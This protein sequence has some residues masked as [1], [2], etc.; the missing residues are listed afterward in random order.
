MDETPHVASPLPDAEYLDTHTVAERQARGNARRSEVSLESLATWS[1]PA[2]RVDPVAVL[3][4]QAGHRVPELVPIRYGRMARVGLRLLP[5]RR[6]H[7]GGRPL[8]HARP[9]GCAPSSAATPT[10]STSA[11][12]RRPER[13]LVFGLNDF[14]ET[15]PGPVRVGRQA[16]RRQRRDRRPRPR[17]RRRPAAHG[18]GGHRPGLPRGHA[19]VR[20]AAQPRRLVRPPPGRRAAHGSPTTGRPSRP[21]KEVKKRIDAGA[22][23]AITCAPSAASVED[24]RR[25]APVLQPPAAARARSRSC[26]TSSSASATS[27][28]SSTFLR[29]YRE[30]L[31]PDRRVLVESYRFV[32][33]GPQGRRRRQRRHPRLGRA[34]RRPRRRRPADPPAQGGPAV[35]ARAL[36]RRDRLRVPGPP[37]R[38]GPAPHAGRQRP[39]LGWYRPRRLRRRSPRL[40]RAPAL[41]RQGLDRRLP[42]R[43]R[44]ASSPTARAAAGPSPAATPAPATASP[45]PPTSATT[46]PSSR[47]SPTFA[48]AYADT[49]EAD[50]A[51]LREAETSG[52]VEVVH[53]V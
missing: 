29:Q 36:R 11:S 15:L 30:S 22:Q 27:R 24:G 41:G 39:L 8:R 50:H 49:N 21:A 35:G 19:R 47:R 40:L 14:D 12:S 6:R 16:P 31:P 7:H 10:C 1:P 18:R 13:T 48:A 45:W 25:P 23:A 43:A 38:R 5:R 33:H 4:R 26:S 34:A 32:A 17:L 53:G 51:R 9:A 44:R 2:T 42:A 52:E 20:R 3:E 37:G 28:S 46:P